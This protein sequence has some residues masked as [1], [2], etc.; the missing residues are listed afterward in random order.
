MLLLRVIIVVSSFER[1]RFRL[2]VKAVKT[3][4]YSQLLRE[5][6]AL[7][8]KECQLFLWPGGKCKSSHLIRMMEAHQSVGR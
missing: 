7:C 3:L 5:G 4:I 8:E 1:F 6:P 2:K